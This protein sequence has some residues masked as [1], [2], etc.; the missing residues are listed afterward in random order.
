[1]LWLA[2]TC[3]LALIYVAQES[4][5]GL[6]A[7]GHAGGLAAFAGG[8]AWTGLV[9]A[10]PVGLLMSLALRG[11]SAAAAALAPALRRLRSARLPVPAPGITR[12]LRHARRTRPMLTARGPPLSSMG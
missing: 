4:A 5:E 12:L 7:A 8:D 9:L 1:V 10:V 6:L 11:P 2:S 3:A